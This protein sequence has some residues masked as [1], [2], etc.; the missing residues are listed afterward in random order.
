MA[1]CPSCGRGTLEP[2]RT[3]KPFLI[4]KEMVTDNEIKSNTVFVDTVQN[5]WGYPEHTVNYYLAKELGM[6]GVQMN[7]LS[8]T[9]LYMHIP[10]KSKKTKEAKA[11]AQAC[12]D[13]SISEV[14]KE[15]EGKKIILLMGA[16]VIRLFTGYSASSVYGLRCKSELL[17]NVSVIIPAP[18]SD[19]LMVMPIGEMRNALK[20]FA[21]EIKLYNEYSKILGG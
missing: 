19:K 15:A 20:V 11:D 12:L 9:N 21:E 18:N 2:K 17:P 1:I 4:V 6:V 16:E 13:F 10:S 5:R 7:T 8:L 3:S 14:I